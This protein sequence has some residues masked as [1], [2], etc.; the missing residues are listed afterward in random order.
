[1]ERKL[2][3]SAGSI[4]DII[5]SIDSANKDNLFVEPVNEY[6]KHWFQKYLAS[7]ATGCVFEP[8]GFTRFAIFCANHNVVIGTK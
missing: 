1:M 5:I 7:E 6:G 3:N 2:K 8:S 4:I